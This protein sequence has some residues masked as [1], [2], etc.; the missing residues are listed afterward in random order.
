[1]K[2]RE[3]G[4]M[5]GIICNLKLLIFLPAILIQLVFHPAWHFA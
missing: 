1:M 3:G 5:G 2:F 4:D